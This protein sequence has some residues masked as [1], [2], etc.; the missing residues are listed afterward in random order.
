MERDDRCKVLQVGQLLGQPPYPG[1]RRDGIVPGSFHVVPGKDEKPIAQG[2]HTFYGKEVGGL[3]PNC[4]RFHTAA[5]DCQTHRPHV[6]TPRSC[7]IPDRRVVPPSRTDEDPPVAANL[8]DAF[9]RMAA[10]RVR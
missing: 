10:E 8:L 9:R 7:Y 5:Q 1:P 3:L 6:Q 2:D 4:R